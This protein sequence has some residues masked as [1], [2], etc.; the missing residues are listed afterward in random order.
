[1]KINFL[2]LLP[3]PKSRH[4]VYT[5]F[6]IKKEKSKSLFNPN[7]LNLLK[8]NKQIKM[9][10]KFKKDRLDQEKYQSIADVMNQH[11][12]SQDLEPIKKNKSKLLKENKSC[13]N[14]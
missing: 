7:N 12:L 5:L 13:N 6:T 14:S 4:K 8:I 2:K 9:F 11:Q 10:H 1:M 3:V